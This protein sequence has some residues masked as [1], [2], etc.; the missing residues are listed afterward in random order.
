MGLLGILIALVGL[1]FF[2]FRG[3]S[4]LILAPI[5]GGTPK[6]R[7]RNWPWLNQIVQRWSETMDI[8]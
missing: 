5:F 8:R 1:I 7:R 2:A 4:I 6:R 3:T